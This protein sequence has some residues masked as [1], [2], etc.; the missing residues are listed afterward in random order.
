MSTCK[1]SPMKRYVRLDSQELV[2]NNKIAISSHGPIMMQTRS[3]NQFLYLFIFDHL[4]WYSDHYH[5]K[6]YCFL[7]MP[8]RFSSSFGDMKLYMLAV[9]LPTV[10]VSGEA[11]N[12]TC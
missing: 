10:H 8:Y 4:T 7:F 2:P 3:D 11:T 5:L 9:R 1:H 6:R 12:C